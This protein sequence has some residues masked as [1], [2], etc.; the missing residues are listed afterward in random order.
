M[1]HLNLSPAG[2]VGMSVGGVQRFLG[3]NLVLDN[4]YELLLRAAM[5]TDYIKS[6]QFALMSGEPIVP[7]L[8]RLTNVVAS[9]LVGSSGDNRP[10]ISTDSS[11]VRSVGTWSASFTASGPLTYDTLG[12]VSSTGLLVAALSVGTTQLVATDPVAINWTIGFR[13]QVA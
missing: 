9:T 12:L 7:A 3:C 8:S 6:V 13:G 4:M 5:D 11:G 1:T 2:F 10:L